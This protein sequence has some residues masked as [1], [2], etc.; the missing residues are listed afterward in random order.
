MNDL[1]LHFLDVGCG[2]MTLILFPN[3]TTYLYDCNVTDDNEDDVL[4]YLGKAMGRR[5]TIQAFICAHRDAAHM[6]CL[7][8][9][10]NLFPIGEIRD[11]GV[12][13]SIFITTLWSFAS[14]HSSFAAFM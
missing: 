14:E 4:A 10:Q 13:N 8:T 5:S 12:P 7:R 3:G 2:N 11:P 9:V 6:R 1:F